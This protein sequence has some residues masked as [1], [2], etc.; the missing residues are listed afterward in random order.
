MKD[1][2]RLGFLSLFG[3]FIMDTIIIVMFYLVSDAFVRPCPLFLLCHC[4]LLQLSLGVSHDQ[5]QKIAFQYHSNTIHI[6]L[7]FNVFLMV[8]EW[9]LNGPRR[10]YGQGYLNGI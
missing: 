8:F 1:R 7:F 4:L 5:L 10:Y 6:P 3:K 9:Y 2:Q